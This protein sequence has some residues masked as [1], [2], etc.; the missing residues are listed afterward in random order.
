[1]SR[2]P[3]CAFCGRKCL[4]LHSLEARQYCSERCGQLHLEY[5]AKYKN[6]QLNDKK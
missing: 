1:M 4:N 6:K 2:K 3:L 5:V